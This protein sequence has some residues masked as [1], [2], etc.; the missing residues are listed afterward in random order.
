MLHI[1]PLMGL[2][3]VLQIFWIGSTYKKNIVGSLELYYV[4]TLAFSG[5]KLHPAH[6]E[7]L[8]NTLLLLP[9]ALILDFHDPFMPRDSISTVYM[10][11][12]NFVKILVLSKPLLRNISI[13]II[14]TE[15]P[16][17]H[18]VC[19]WRQ[20]DLRELFVQQ[21]PSLIMFQS[22]LVLDILAIRKK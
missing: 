16:L 12:S 20:C 4:D 21:V 19:L 6:K 2:L 17:T 13:P 22:I 18:K 8:R 11:H 14:M 5:N 10:I 15:T 9:C 3:S 7:Q 1:Q